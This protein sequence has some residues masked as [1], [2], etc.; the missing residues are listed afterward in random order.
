M[1]MVVG[2]MGVRT[3]NTSK[4]LVRNGRW[5]A[6]VS[7]SLSLPA[8]LS[9]ADARVSARRLCREKR[10]RLLKLQDMLVIIAG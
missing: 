4:S 1:I 7:V 5:K 3:P 9:D 2:V 8:V 6:S 10:I